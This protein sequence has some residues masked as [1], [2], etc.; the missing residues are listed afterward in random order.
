M[1]DNQLTP[2]MIDRAKFLIKKYFDEKGYKN[3]EI[4]ILQRDDVAAPDKT[5]VDIRIDK[6]EKV[7]IHS[8]TIEGN[9]ALS[10]KK[11]KGTMFVPGVSRRPTR[12]DVPAVGSVRRNL[13]R[14]STRKTRKT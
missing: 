9:H 11:I 10:T 13:L 14:K 7:K 8:I 5:I 2:N 4:E 6:K 12:K 3:A 1:K